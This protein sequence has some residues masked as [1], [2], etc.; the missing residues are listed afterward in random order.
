MD[1]AVCLA[2]LPTARSRGRRRRLTLPHLLAPSRRPPSRA[3]SFN[4]DPGQKTIKLE[5]AIPLLQMLVPP[6]RWPLVAPLVAFLTARPKAAM[7]KD[8][9]AQLL[10]LWDTVP[11]LAK[12]P[13]YGESAAWPTLFDDFVEELEKQQAKT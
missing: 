10:L 6:A 2:R 9:W 7:P 8:T 12:L 13:A 11:T 1:G 3:R 4:C 5:A